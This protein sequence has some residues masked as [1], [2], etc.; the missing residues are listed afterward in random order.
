[1]KS[2]KEYKEACKLFT[3]CL[4]TGKTY[5]PEIRKNCLENLKEILGSQNLLSK[6]P[7]IIK[8]LEHYEKRKNNDIVFLLDSSESMGTEPRKDYATREILNV[9]EIVKELY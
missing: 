8:I 6:A 5:S 4:E 2:G 9:T 7:N 1:M 3:E